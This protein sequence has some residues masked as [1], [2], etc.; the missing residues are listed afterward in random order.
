MAYD[1]KERMPRSQITLFQTEEKIAQQ[2]AERQEQ[3]VLSDFMNYN[4]RTPRRTLL[5]KCV[6]M[7]MSFIAT[8]RELLKKYYTEIPELDVFLSYGEDNPKPGY[9]LSGSFYCKLDGFNLCHM[10]CRAEDEGTKVA[11]TVTWN[12]GSQPR[13]ENWVLSFKFVRVRL[14]RKVILDVSPNFKHLKLREILDFK[15]IDQQDAVPAT[16]P[17]TKS[18]CR[19]VTLVSMR[20]CLDALTA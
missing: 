5:Q 18:P 20:S 15:M 4:W 10:S 1:G 11:V 6:Q 16:L 13:V 19:D 8:Q 7:N 3:K 17:N 2:K 9:K 14:K 12:I